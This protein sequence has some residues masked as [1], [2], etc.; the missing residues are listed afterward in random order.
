MV[1]SG[2]NQK[3]GPENGSSLRRD[4]AILLDEIRVRKDPKAY[5]EEQLPRL[6]DLV[7]RYKKDIDR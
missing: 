3:G 5:R 4:I 2:A 7:A 1:V 6:K